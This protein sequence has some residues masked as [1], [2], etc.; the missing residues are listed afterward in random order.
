MLSPDDIRT[1]LPV[2][3]GLPI[4]AAVA[5]LFARR[6]AGSFALGAALLHL[7]LTALVVAS[8]CRPLAE[9]PAV[10]GLKRNFKVS[11]PLFVPGSSSLQGPDSHATSWDVLPFVSFNDDKVRSIQFYTGLDGLNVWLVALASR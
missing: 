10:K 2:L 4:A 3:L 8:A 5:V 1:L 9:R 7:V 11:E 6:S